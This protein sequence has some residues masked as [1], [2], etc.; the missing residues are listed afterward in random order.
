MNTVFDAFGEREDWIELYNSGGGNVNLTGYFLSDDPNKLQKWEIPPITD[1]TPGG[2]KMIFC[3]NRDLVHP[4]TGQMHPSFKLRQSNGEWFILSDAVGGIIDSVHLFSGKT[5][6]NNSRGRTSDGAATWSLFGTPTPNAANMNPFDGYATKPIMSLAPGNYTAAQN[7]TLSSPDPNVTIHY[8]TNGSTPSALS[9]VYAA[10]IPVAATTAIRA[11]AVSSNPLILPSFPETNTYFINESSNFDVVSVCGPYDNASATNGQWLFSWAAPRIWSSFEYF[12]NNLN[13]EF[14]LDGRA[15]KHGQ[16]SWA[17]PQKG[18]DFEAMDETGTSASFNQKLFGTSLRDTF[19]R[20][21]LKAGGSDNYAG[22]PNNSAH[23]R[24]VW[25]QTLSEKYGLEM[26]F[27]RWHPTLMFVNGEY[28]GLYDLRERVDGDYFEY[29]YGKKRD[30]VDH[31][32]YWGGLNVRLGSDT[33]WVNLYNFIVN[34]NMAVPANYDY[35]KT[36]LNLK[37][38]CQYF[39]LNTYLVNHDW[40]NWNT[41]WWRGRGNNNS[42][43][44]RYALWDMDAICGLDNPNYTNLSTTTYQFDPCEPTSLFQNNTNIK[45]TDML[46]NLLDNADFDQLYKDQWIYMFN[47]PLDCANIIAQLDSVENIMDPEMTRQSNAWGGTYAGWK[48]NVQEV[49][50]FVNLRCAVIGD[51]LDSCMELK[52]VKLQLNVEPPNTGIVSL[53]GS[54]KSPYVWSKVII[55]DSTYS[56]EGVPIAGPYWSF[57]YW[58]KQ[59]AANIFTPNLTTSL[60]NVDL[61]EDDSVIAHFKYYNFDSVDVTFDVQ[62]PGT[63]QISLEGSIIPVYPTTIRLDRLRQ[64]NIEALPDVSHIF[65]NWG[66]NNTSTVLGNALAAQTTFEYVDPETFTAYFKYIP[67]PPPPPPLPAIDKTVFIPTAFSP[68]GDGNND[69]FHVKIGPD[70]IGMDM[71]IFNRWGEEIYRTNE[72]R[73]GWDGMYKGQRAHVGSYHYQIHLKYRDDSVEKHVGDVILLQ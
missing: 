63:G 25:A 37:S 38:F 40:L 53:D 33:G 70:V 47:G 9:Q 73:I 26:D 64:Y 43:K 67:P 58:E 23:M 45:H 68:N 13:F 27:R 49:R 60:V 14:E 24:D 51:K 17:Y 19:D 4:G 18:I 15:S 29:Y 20:I 6:I 59:D 35:V 22:G 62:P 44:W 72:A 57:D 28:W 46:T 56:L 71:R 42:V 50:D 2:R 32:S 61:Q 34:N 54:V 30:K 8:T 52:P 11:I 5:Q 65:L 55:G 10:P 16:D 48:A 69:A 41:M 39:I 3:S 21:M 36:Q 12:D 7:V 1:I 31:L 66:K